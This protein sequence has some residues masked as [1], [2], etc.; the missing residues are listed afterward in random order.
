[1]H[2]H[3][4]RLP[5]WDDAV[6]AHILLLSPLETK[7]NLKPLGMDLAKSGQHGS[8]VATFSPSTT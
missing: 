1:M 7:W 4:C 6:S 8:A 2:A 5:F 3:F